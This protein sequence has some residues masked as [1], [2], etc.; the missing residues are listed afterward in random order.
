MSGRETVWVIDDDRSIRWVL[1]RALRQEGMDVTSFDSGRGVLERLG[2]QSP[3]V[4][5]SDIRMPD[6]DGLQLLDQIG[7]RRPGLPVIIM[8]AYSDLDSTVAAYQGGAFDY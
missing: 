2:S 7:S 1:E 6:T 3:D 4:I 8:T 5:I